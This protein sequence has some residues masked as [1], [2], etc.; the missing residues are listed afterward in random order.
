[1][2]S[3]LRVLS[4]LLINF[5]ELNTPIRRVEGDGSVAANGFQ[6]AMATDSAAAAPVQQI[7]WLEKIAGKLAGG[8]LK[9]IYGDW[10]DDEYYE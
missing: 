5:S 2:P 6:I 9:S 4:C 8:K 10:I 3:I 1:M 7:K